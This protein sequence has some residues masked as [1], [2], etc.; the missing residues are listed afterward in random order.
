MNGGD[1][2]TPPAFTGS[3]YNDYAPTDLS[4]AYMVDQECSGTGDS[5]ITGLAAQGTGTIIVF[6]NT[7][8][9]N[10]YFLH[11]HSGSVAA[12]RFSLPSSTSAILEPGYSVTLR[13]S[14]SSWEVIAW[15]TELFYGLTVNT[16]ARLHQVCVSDAQTYSTTGSSDDV[17][18][19]SD[20]TV[21]QYTGAGDATITGLT[22]TGAGRVL[23]IENISGHN[24][25]L[26]NA[27]SSSSAGHQLANVNDEDVVLSGN[28]S[29]ATYVYDNVAGY[30]RMTSYASG[31]TTSASTVLGTMAASSIAAGG[32][33]IAAAAGVLGPAQASALSS[34]LWVGL[35]T[36]SA[37]SGASVVARYAGPMVLTTTEWDAVVTGGS[38]GLVAGTQYYVDAANPGKLVA[39]PPSATGTFI[40]P[41]GI[42]TDSTVL[43]VGGCGNVMG[44]L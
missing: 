33:L 7:G 37:S 16:V 28:N 38:G 2:I 17:V 35:A 43:M 18:V 27:S 9:F 29:S 30:W 23:I 34:S 40:A 1:K 25:T 3:T 8:P 4:T 42:A 11:Q 41:V 24:L 15:V 39:A 19:N 31:T 21:F 5:F 26:T 44:P 36:S 13:Y 32:P 6:R 10:L 22:G 12:N 14:G 20:A